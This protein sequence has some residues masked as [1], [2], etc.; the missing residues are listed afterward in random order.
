MFRR[1]LDI[2]LK[3]A[4]AVSTST[5]VLQLT[6]PL[7]KGTSIFVVTG[8]IMLTFVFVVYILSVNSL[9]ASNWSSCL[10]PQTQFGLWMI[11]VGAILVGT[12]GW[13]HF[14]PTVGFWAIA[15][16]LLTLCY[17]NGWRWLI[18]LQKVSPNNEG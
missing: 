5:V 9:F 4:F 17:R 14:E 18:Q 16:F 12:H 13:R 8:Q 15:A 7:P 3:G 1:D 6:C 10:R 11:G 2:V